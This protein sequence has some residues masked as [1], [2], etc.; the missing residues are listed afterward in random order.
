[1]RYP[2]HGPDPLWIPSAADDAYAGTRSLR[3]N[4]WGANSQYDGRRVLCTNARIRC[5]GRQST[6]VSGSR[7]GQADRDDEQE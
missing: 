1:M 4:G 7:Y 5:L 2:N 6:S 3:R